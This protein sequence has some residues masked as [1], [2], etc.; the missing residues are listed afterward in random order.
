MNSSFNSYDVKV[1]AIQRL[2]AVM[3]LLSLWSVS[4][5]NPLLTIVGF[6]VLPILIY[7]L[8]EPGQPPTF[9]FVVFYQWLQVLTPVIEANIKGVVLGYD[10]NLPQQIT[11][12]YLGYVSI[13]TLAFGIRYGAAFKF[14]CY[15]I[16]KHIQIYQFNARRLFNLYLSFFL[17]SIFLKSVMW[18]VPSL[19]QL[20][21]SLRIYKWAVVFFIIWIAVLRPDLRALARSVV[22]IEVLIGFL[23][24]FA[25]FKTVFIFLFVCIL[26]HEKNPNAIIKMRYLLLVSLM[27]LF[28]FAWQTI[29][30]DYRDF[31]RQG[32]L[33]QVSKV[34]V[35]EKANYLAD[36]VASIPPSFVLSGF[37]S[38]ASRLGYTEFFGYT[39]DR[40]PQVI[41][42]QDGRLWANAI[43]HVLKPR[44]L[45]PEKAAL[46]DSNITREYAGLNVANAED[47]ASI[48]LG[49]AAESYIDFGP[50]LMFVPIFCIGYIYG[51]GYRLFLSIP[52]PNLIVFSVANAYVITSSFLFESS[53]I[54]ILGGL[55]TTI[56][57]N[58]IILKIFSKSRFSR[59][60]SPDQGI[61][62]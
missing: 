30:M 48:G 44:F 32:D 26:A 21:G 5:S 20:I 36:A 42:F 2:S 22:I 40:V 53:G 10:I 54:K 57:V 25:D 62:P 58:Y 4:T 18:L 12:T 46:D 8:W 17:F 1:A 61:P 38:F 7:F 27:L 14:I 47:G 45:F 6:F 28:A 51:F 39:I 13:I 41:P 55:L 60:F 11:A 9:L 16:E 33:T 35:I 19:T 15:G 3:F 31:Q 43:L 29:K 50:F 24:F 34:S 49:Y 23:G 52:A 59:F 37:E 56:F